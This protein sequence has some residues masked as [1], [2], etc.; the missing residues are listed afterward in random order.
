MPHLYGAK[1]ASSKRNVVVSQNRSCDADTRAAQ[2]AEK[3]KAF[4]TVPTFRVHSRFFSTD[5]APLNPPRSP[6]GWCLS[7]VPRGA[8]QTTTP[9]RIWWYSRAIGRSA[10]RICLRKR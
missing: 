9:V 3:L 5:D 10:G 7:M 6:F 1:V 8:C 2:T 4:S